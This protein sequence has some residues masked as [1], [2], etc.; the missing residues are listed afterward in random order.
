[1]TGLTASNISSSTPLRHEELTR[2]NSYSTSNEA[3]ASHNH[4]S[5][6]TIM[7]EEEGAID[8]P[9]N[10]PSLIQVSHK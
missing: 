3:A 5:Q 7:S 4:E 9:A 8:V 6:D 10:V 1:M 2:P